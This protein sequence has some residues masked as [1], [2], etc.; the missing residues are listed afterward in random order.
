LG[1]SAS[2]QADEGDRRGRGGPKIVERLS[3]DLRAAFPSARGFSV[4]SLRYMRA[5]A[6][7]WPE[8]EML[9]HG[10][11]A[12]PWGHIT[13]LL[14][15]LADRPTQ[16]WYAERAGPWSRAQLEAAIAS[17][18]HEREGAAITNFEQALEIGGEEF[19]LDLLF[20]HHPTRR[21]VVIDLKIG[22]FQP[23]FAG[24]MNLHVNA[25]D[26]FI[27]NEEDRSTV[28]FTLSRSG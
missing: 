22:P 8:R 17:R 3:S 10:V 21:F 16:D 2:R 19:I 25:V 4:S 5:F 27:A 14:D 13:R 26:E 1:Q 20:F 6:A 11:G 24:K 23:E 12:L 18:L 9:Q 7:A 28:G 15:R